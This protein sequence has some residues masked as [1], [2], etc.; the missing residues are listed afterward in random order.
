MNEQFITSLLI[1]LNYPADNVITINNSSIVII[2]NTTS[3]LLRKTSQTGRAL[4]G[5]IWLI[6]TQKA[7]TFLSFRVKGLFSGEKGP[8]I[9]QSHFMLV[10]Y[11]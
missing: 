3:K 7:I 10:C 6:G 1:H 5:G 4:V 9:W 2:F 8:I 11:R